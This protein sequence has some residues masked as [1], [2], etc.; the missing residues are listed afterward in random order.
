MSTRLNGQEILK[1]EDLLRLGGALL[2][3][4]LCMGLPSTAALLSCQIPTMC[5]LHAFENT[6]SPPYRRGAAL[7]ST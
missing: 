1:S 7:T 6:P 3:S 4:V 2:R 5:H